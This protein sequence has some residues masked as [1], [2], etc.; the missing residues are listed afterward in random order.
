MERIQK[1]VSGNKSHSIV[2]IALVP[3]EKWC[4][5]KKQKNRSDSNWRKFQE[6]YKNNIVLLFWEELLESILHCNVKRYM[7]KRLAD[8]YEKCQIA[9]RKNSRV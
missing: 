5:A 3:E 1:V 4:N 2:P 8:I 9:S 7:E 6:C